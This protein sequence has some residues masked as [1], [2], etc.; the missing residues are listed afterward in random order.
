MIKVDCGHFEYSDKTDAPVSSFTQEDVEN[1]RIVFVHNKSMANESYVTLQVS[2]GI[3]SSAF[4]KLRVSTF[5]QVWWLQNNTGLILTHDAFAFITPYNLSF[6]SNVASSDDSAQFQVVQG[7]QYGLIEVENDF[8]VWKNTVIFTTGQLKQHRVR[9][10]HI[11]AQPEFDEFQ[12][13]Y[14]R[15]L[16]CLVIF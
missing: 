14:C 1:G 12:V 5:Q 10:H 11:S 16:E 4:T 8:G 13:N 9:Y 15:Y 3:E 6:I 7:P 2:D